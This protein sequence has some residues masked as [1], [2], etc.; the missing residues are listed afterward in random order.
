MFYYKEI[1][2]Y[3]WIIWD[4]KQLVPLMS[5]LSNHNKEL[6]MSEDFFNIFIYL[7]MFD[8]SDKFKQI[9]EQLFT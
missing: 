1:K 4:Y 9:R 6:K 3:L 8:K 7:Y 5:K 2:S